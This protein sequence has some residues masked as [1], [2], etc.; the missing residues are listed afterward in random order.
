MARAPPTPPP[1]HAI[2]ADRH[3]PLLQQLRDCNARMQ[4]RCDEIVAVLEK[5]KVV[6]ASRD[7]TSP[8]EFQQSLR[9][10]GV[11]G[12]DQ[13]LEADEVRL[14]SLASID[15]L[16]AAF[17]KGDDEN[18]PEFPVQRPVSPRRRRDTSGQRRQ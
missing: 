12:E 6:I 5:L 14:P 2:P 7:T 13:L 4:T 15:A 11:L 9:E 18:L 10:L 8:E 17:A 1:E 3:R 16:C